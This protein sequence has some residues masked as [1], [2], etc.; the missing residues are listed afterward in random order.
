MTPPANPA[1]EYV[2]EPQPTDA[3]R[4]ELIA[5]IEQAP[6]QLSRAVAGLSDEQLNAKYL[7]WS[8]RQIV[9]HI[10]DSHAHSYIRCKWTLT[11]EQ[12]LIKAYDENLW[13]ALPDA[14]EGNIAAPLAMLAGVHQCWVQILRAMTPAD[15]A[16]SFNHPETGKA[17][18]LNDALSYYAW[19]GQ[20]HTAQIS[21]LR[22]QH[23]W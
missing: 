9:Q 8:I 18:V 15:F 3:R 5:I 16:R 12:P 11:E 23:G 21:W 7:N 6:Q 19:H 10:A 22:E 14:R 20:H 1:G 4:A 13:S 2:A 17:V